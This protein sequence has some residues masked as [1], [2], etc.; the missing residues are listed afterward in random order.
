MDGYNFD[1][2]YKQLSIPRQR[3]E[4]FLNTVF[5]ISDEKRRYLR[6]FKGII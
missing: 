5:E 1:N 3:Q 6:R 2:E 4:I